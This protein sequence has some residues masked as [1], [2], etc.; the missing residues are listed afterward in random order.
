MNHALTDCP[1]PASA[2]PAAASRAVL[3]PLA[4]AALQQLQ[5]RA[6]TEFVTRMLSTYL[7]SLHKHRLLAEQAWQQ[8]QWEALSHSAHALKAA[9]ASMGAA[10][11]AQVCAQLELAIRQGEGASSPKAVAEL[12]ALFLAEIAR[13]AAAVRDMPGVAA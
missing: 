5:P 1:V 13:V 6:G 10:H 9:S 3:D 7:R 12:G 8:E 4:L 11:L 2:A